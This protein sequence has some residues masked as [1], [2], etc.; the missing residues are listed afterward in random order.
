MI[1]HRAVP[2]LFAASVLAIGSGAPRRAL[3]SVRANPNTE[4]AGRL[5]GDTLTVALEAQQSAWRP[6]GDA[7]PSMTIEAFA[8]PGKAP[9]IPGPL[10]RATQKTIIR[11][12]VRNS[13]ATPL[14]FF[15]PLALRGGP[16]RMDAMDSVVVAPGAVGELSTRATVPGN[17]V[18][19]A[20]TPTPIAIRR[21]LAGLLT[22]AMVV[23]TA[24]APGKPK[25]RVLVLQETP[26]SAFVA[27][28]S[29][30]RPPALD[31]VGRLLYTING[32]SW[33][34]TERIHA[35]VGD[36]LHWRVIN[37][38][39][40]P[41]PMHL[42]GFYYRVDSFTGPLVGVEGQ[43]PPHRLVVTELMWPFSSMSM[44]WS[45]DRPGNWLF[46]CHFAVHLEPDSMSAAPD[47]PHHRGMVGLVVGILVAPRSTAHDVAALQAGTPRR[48]MARHLRLVAV[49]DTVA[50]DDSLPMAVPSMRFVLE[51][52]GR[53][54]EAALGHS[55]ELDLV[56]G[57][58]VSITIVN[59][60]DEPTSVHWHGIEVQDSYVDGVAGFSGAG[61]HL[62]PEIAPG[63]SFTAHF[64]PPR[65]GTFMYHAH[66]DEVRQDRAGMM[67]PLIVRD[68]GAAPSPDD[69]VFFLNGS[70]RGHLDPLEINGTIAS[71]TVVLRVG[72]TARLRLL[73]LAWTNPTPMIALTAEPNPASSDGRD[74]NA[75]RWTPVAKDGFDLPA[76]EQRPRPARQVISMGETYDFA[77]TP[78]RA[79]LFVLTARP[80][81][82]P[83]IRVPGRIFAQVV[84]RAE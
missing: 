25:D 82:P 57:Q 8:E 40:A 28:F 63:D 23:D 42:H 80:N 55:P 60:L 49:E 22:G 20:T 53:R 11:F 56:R 26:D 71:D 46:H 30:S 68:P 14:T 48:S 67:G 43:G 79:G 10:V 36:S 1:M 31:T 44:A 47:D 81:P 5:R 27:N 9:L 12:A 50:G 32:R 7:H 70:R 77:F 76:A 51:E 45:P 73:S 66:M 24:D 37:A 75:V 69:Q 74:T 84:I 13:L 4:R 61:N 17:Y 78:P 52:N 65:A 29:P 2:A 33:P 83:G 35:T 39:A 21:G 18:Y 59:H 6:D 54:T 62:A 34:N 3:P 41:H 16:D 15:V 38:S 72:R 58:P 19:R 64:T